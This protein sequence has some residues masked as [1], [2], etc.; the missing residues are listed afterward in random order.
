M[1]KIPKKQFAFYVLHTPKKKLTN[2]QKKV[3]QI[4]EITHVCLRDGIGKDR[5]SLFKCVMNEAEQRLAS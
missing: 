3:K 5:D 2:Q 4:S 1:E